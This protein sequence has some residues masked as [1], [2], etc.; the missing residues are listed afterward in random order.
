MTTNRAIIFDPSQIPEKTLIQRGCGGYTITLNKAKAT[1]QFWGA[2]NPLEISCV[3]VHENTDVLI[4][5]KSADE[6][7]LH[8]EKTLLL[9]KAMVVFLMK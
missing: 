6:I 7:L 2:W 4:S 5:S 9:S 8:H 1:L 3:G